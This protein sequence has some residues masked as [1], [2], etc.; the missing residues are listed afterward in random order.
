MARLLPT[1]STSN[2]R[3]DGDAAALIN[4]VG[5]LL[6]VAHDSMAEAAGRAVGRRAQALA[7]LVALRK[8]LEDATIQQLGDVIGLTHSAT[9]RLV[10][11]LVADGYVLRQG[12][13]RD[14]RT[15]AICLTKA[16]TDAAERVR[17]AR[18]RAVEEL[19]TALSDQERRAL[20]TQLDK[21]LVG[22]ARRRLES[23]AQ[24]EPVGGWMC[25]FCDLGA[26]GRPEGRCPVA[27][28]PA[29]E[30]S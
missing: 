29:A 5:A 24:D 23:R 16:G 1:R 10:N 18:R 6:L 13:G 19:L 25:R 26:C 30:T 2:S 27:A 7:A 9:V 3:A 28:I 11:R 8:F 20:A 14:G 12:S 4:R 15:V 17:Q 21:L 22:V